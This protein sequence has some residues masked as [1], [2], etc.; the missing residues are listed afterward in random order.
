[1]GGVARFLEIGRQ[2][3]M[4]MVVS[5]ALDS[6]VGMSRGLLAAACLPE[7]R[8]ACGLGT[9]GLFVEDVAESPGLVDGHLPVSSVA[10]DPA[11]LAGLAAA[12]ERRGW[13]IERIRACYPL[14]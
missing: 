2:C 6:A 12:S 13:W 3:D 5:S 10:P 1:L 9:G 7:L 4:S 8:H 11:R 14:L